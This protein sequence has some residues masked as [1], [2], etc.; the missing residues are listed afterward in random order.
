MATSSL[1]ESL[2]ISIRVSAEKTVPI[3][4]EVSWNDYSLVAIFVGNIGNFSKLKII[5][6]DQALFLSSLVPLPD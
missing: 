5:G 3:F 2:I 4:R 6:L 1:K